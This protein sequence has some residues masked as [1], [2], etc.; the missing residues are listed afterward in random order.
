MPTRVM[1]SWRAGDRVRWSGQL[2][3][4]VTDLNDGTHAH[5]RIGQRLYRV[6]LAD[7]TRA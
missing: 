3:W 6:R 4:F 1:Q 7:L 2:G 5:I